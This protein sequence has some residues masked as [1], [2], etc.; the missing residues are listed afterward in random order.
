MARLPIQRPPGPQLVQQETRALTYAP[1]I[2]S[3]VTWPIAE[4]LKAIPE[5]KGL[6]PAE[7]QDELPGILQKVG[8][9]VRAF[10]ENFPNTVSVENVSTARLG[11]NAGYSESIGQK[12]QYLALARPLNQSAGLDEYRTTTKG[13][14]VEPGGLAGGYFITQGFVSTPLHF[15]PSRQADSTFRYLGRQEV[16]KRQA[17]VVAFAQR[18]SVARSVERFSFEE[19]AVLLLV[20]GIA[21]IDSSTYEVLHMRTDL[22]PHKEEIG[23]TRVTTE[24]EFEEVHFKESHQVLWLPREVVVRT[25]WRGYTYLNKHRY[26]NFRLFVVGTEEKVKAP[27]DAPSG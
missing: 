8:E 25:D 17:Y 1:D 15:L 22:L 6:K 7:S 5:L 27:H 11:W 10:F 4:L 26:S 2:R 13:K 3:V 12:F 14:P 9:N 16:N 24:V 20:Q 23:P 19:I 21:W 18:P